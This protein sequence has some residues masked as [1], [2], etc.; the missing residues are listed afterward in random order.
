MNVQIEQT[1]GSM[2]V[3]YWIWNSED[4]TY[5]FLKPICFSKLESCAE[6]FWVQDSTDPWAANVIVSGLS[7]KVG[8]PA[9]VDDLK[10]TVCSICSCFRKGDFACGC[11][12]AWNVDGSCSCWCCYGTDPAMILRGNPECLDIWFS[13]EVLLGQLWVSYVARNCPN[14]R[15]EFGV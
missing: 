7:I 9:G 1:V 14:E 13:R 4:V 3:L 6:F 2:G 11:L 10:L 12:G 5:D 15:R 8:I